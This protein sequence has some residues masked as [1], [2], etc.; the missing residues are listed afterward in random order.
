MLLSFILTPDLLEWTTSIHCVLCCSVF[1]TTHRQMT[2]SAGPIATDI[3]D[4]RILCSHHRHTDVQVSGR[5]RSRARHPK[6]ATIR[7][8]SFVKISTWIWRNSTASTW[9]AN[10]TLRRWHARS[11]GFELILIATVHLGYVVEQIAITLI[12]II[13]SSNGQK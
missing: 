11:V 6:L 4:D 1:Y 3:L 12:F 13:F 10:S 9:K 5:S 7:E 8:I 2:H